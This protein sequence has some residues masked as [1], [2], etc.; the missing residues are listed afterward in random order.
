M[1]QIAV[2]PGFLA[3]FDLYCERSGMDRW[4]ADDF[5]HRVREDYDGWAPVITRAAAV[6]RFTDATWG[7]TLGK[8]RMPS[9]RLCE[10]YMASLG[11]FP[12]PSFFRNDALGILLEKCAE[13]AGVIE[14]A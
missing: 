1:N 8:G 11:Y 14:P 12:D 13:L 3:D 6:Y 10:G 7:P 2:P 5:K 9:V 4:A